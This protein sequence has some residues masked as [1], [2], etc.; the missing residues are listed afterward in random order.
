MHTIQMNRFNEVR[1]YVI[2]EIVLAMPLQ[3]KLKDADQKM[4]WVEAVHMCECVSN[5]MATTGS[6]T[7]RLEI[8]FGKNI[9][10]IGLFLQFKRIVYDIKRDVAVS[11]EIGR[12][13]LWGSRAGRSRV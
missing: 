4:L 1:F 3:A 6:T 10:I 7:S 9:K 2:K 5:I 13:S 8:L 11:D 12:A